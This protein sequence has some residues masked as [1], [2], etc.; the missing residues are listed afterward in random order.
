MKNLF[1]GTVFAAIDP[2]AHS[3]VARF[4]EYGRIEYVYQGKLLDAVGL[5]ASWRVP[6]IV[7]VP[8]IYP[9]ARARPNDQITLAV[10]AGMFIG[11]APRGCAIEVKPREWK[12]Q[13]DKDVIH[14][15]AARCFDEAERAYL[16]SVASTFG[17]KDDDVQ[18]AIALGLYACGRVDFARPNR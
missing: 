18:D 8:Q 7:E 12:G 14:K 9:N 5:I 17:K 11:A 2:G 13:A 1:P 6:I 10:R 4:D 15:R 16:L 3:G